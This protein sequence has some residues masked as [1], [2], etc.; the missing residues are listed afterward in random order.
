[1]CLDAQHWITISTAA[2]SSP[3][4]LKTFQLRHDVK[5]TLSGPRRYCEIC[6]L[7]D[8]SLKT[9]PVNWSSRK[10]TGSGIGK[11][12]SMSETVRDGSRRFIGWRA[13]LW[14]R[15]S[16]R[17]FLLGD[18]E[19][20]NYSFG[21]RRPVPT[22]PRSAPHTH[23]HTHTTIYMSTQMDSSVLDLSLGCNSLQCREQ[24]L[25]QYAG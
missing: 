19:K 21:A 7:R 13:G 2:A 15:F 9:I 25:M 10:W 20:L 12:G 14:L 17:P 22:P 1:M 11:R 8:S 18:E 4:S 16:T 3:A 5:V 6:Q 23:T 24:F